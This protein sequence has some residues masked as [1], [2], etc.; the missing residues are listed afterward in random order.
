MI[1]WEVLL[2]LRNRAQEK[3]L[4]I[5]KPEEDCEVVV[6]QVV[7]EEAVNDVAMSAAEMAQAGAADFTSPF[8]DELDTPA[9]LRRRA[10]EN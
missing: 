3:K 2:L 10:T 4:S 1:G 5:I 8:E 9:F 7:A 6:V